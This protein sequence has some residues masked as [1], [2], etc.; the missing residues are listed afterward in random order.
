MTTTEAF[1]SVG[2]TARERDLTNAEG[3]AVSL[4]AL[5]SERPLVLIF[6]CSLNS[7][8]GADNAIRLRDAE[9]TYREAGAELVAVVPEKPAEA[10]A[11]KKQWNIP[12]QVLCDPE[13]E[14]Y[15]AFG[16]SDEAPGSFVIDS[17]GVIRYLYRSANGLDNPSTWEL[18]DAVC[19][20]TGVT[21][22]KPSLPSADPDDPTSGGA[23]E[24]GYA[25]PKPGVHA[26]GSYSCPKCSNTDYDVID[27]STSSG[28]MSRLVKSKPRGFSA[29]VCRRC[30]YTEFYRTESGMMPSVFDVV[31]G[32]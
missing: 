24:N 30:T 26:I 7:G 4:P 32:S 23:N 29:V 22:E 16:V 10:D 3:R 5:W 25:A 27:L 2:D 19:E 14:L 21:I 9:E 11:F 28:M 12:F 17:D 31:I 18:V 13:K 20:L 8:Y 15:R 1:L 6:L